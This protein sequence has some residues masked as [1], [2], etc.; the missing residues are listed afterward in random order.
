MKSGSFCY[1]MSP[2]TDK[3]HQCTTA[4]NEPACIFTYNFSPDTVCTPNK[5]N[6]NRPNCTIIIISHA[7]FGQSASGSLYPIL[8]LPSTEQPTSLFVYTFSPMT[9]V[10]WFSLG[11][12]TFPLADGAPMLAPTPG[13]RPSSSEL[14]ASEVDAS[15]SSSSPPSTGFPSTPCCPCSAFSAFP[16]LPLSVWYDEVLHRHHKHHIVSQ[17]R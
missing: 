14:E 2:S 1:C 12:S 13:A 11:T 15:S 6:I 7:K 9:T 16:L 4:L 17:D 5:F 8:N 3:L 10:P